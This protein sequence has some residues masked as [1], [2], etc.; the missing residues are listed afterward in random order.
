MQPAV[1]AKRIRDRAKG[2]RFH[3][4]NLARM[5]YDFLFDETRNLLAIG[6]T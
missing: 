2:L 5:E 3:A 1:P 4:G 6:T